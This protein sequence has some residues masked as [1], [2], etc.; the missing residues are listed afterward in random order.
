MPGLLLAAV[1]Q[2]SL[3]FDNSLWL[4]ITIDLVFHA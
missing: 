1:I 3:L 2:D 4:L